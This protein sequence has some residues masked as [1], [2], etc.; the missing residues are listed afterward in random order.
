MGRRALVPLAL[1]GC[2]LA[3]AAPAEAKQ[4]DLIGGFTFSPTSK[5]DYRTAA[6]ALGYD[7][8]G[9]SAQY[10]GELA[11][12]FGV[13]YHGWLTVGPLLRGSF[14]RLGAPYGGVS[15]VTT[16]AAFVAAR[17]EAAVLGYP[18]LF[19]WADAGLGLSW[20]GTT[21][22]VVG[23]VWQVR[24]G[25]GMRL[26]TDAGGARLRFGYGTAPTFSKVTGLGRYDFGGFVLALDGVIRV[27]G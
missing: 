24:G 9:K 22:H 17:A 15:P 7:T 20:I 19:F 8:H 3:A 4:I 21:D 18:R 13:G 12:T 11:A 26:G 5:S 25:A 2:V 1:A 14:G 10:E 6:D 16:D 27:L 23:G